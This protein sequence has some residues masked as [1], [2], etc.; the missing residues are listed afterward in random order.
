MATIGLECLLE[1][2]YAVPLFITHADDPGETIWW[3]SPA[4]LARGRGIEVAT[5][6]SLAEPAA[7]ARIATAA[8]DFLFSFYYR[9]MMAAGI[10]AIPQRGALNLHGSLLPRY[11]GRA[12]INWVLVQGESTTG[13]TLHYMDEKPDHG[14]IVDQVAI[15][16][17]FEDTART[18]FDKAADAARVL[19]RR[20]L[21]SLAAG[22]AGRRPQAHDQAS[23]FGRR[24]PAD[25][26]IDWS[27]PPLRIHNLVR[28]VT[29][30]Y[31]GAFT[32][33]AGR[34]LLVWSARPAAAEAPRSTPAARGPSA[35]TGAVI[36][37]A[38]GGLLVACGGGD[39][40]VRL[41]QFENGPD[42][43]DAAALARA[44]PAGTRLG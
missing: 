40:L 7:T 39:L 3:R 42:L 15:P 18:L 8:P 44:L 5:P 1:S 20:A 29:R 24:T 14:D 43:A 13:V 6:A 36:G 23:Y 26:R 12:P 28:A 9:S 31:P 41:A 37:A 32:E 38:E 10:L 27:W 16:I 30:P 34:R 25:G 33:V 4:A 17:D 2:G 11:R 35:E 21:P 19:L 22:T